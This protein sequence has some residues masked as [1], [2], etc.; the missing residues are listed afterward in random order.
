VLHRTRLLQRGFST[1]NS[2][3]M[4]FFLGC[5]LSCTAWAQTPRQ[6][7]GEQPDSVASAVRGLQE[8]VRQ[9]REAVAE[10]RSEAAQ[11]RAETVA[12]R[13]E[14][15][16]TREQ[17]AASGG[18]PAQNASAATQSAPS[19]AQTTGVTQAATQS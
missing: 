14:V 19:S 10:M 7:A 1:C 12:L 8:Q 16:A 4:L 13:E 2:W 18:S 6:A 9:L 15:R 5:L 3:E 17:L 11:Y